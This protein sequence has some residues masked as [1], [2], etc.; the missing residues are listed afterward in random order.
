MIPI[1]ITFSWWNDQQIIHLNRI[2][3]HVPWPTPPS[4]RARGFLLAVVAPPVLPPALLLPPLQGLG[5]A[6]EEPVQLE[7][8][9]VCQVKPGKEAVEEWDLIEKIGKLDENDINLP[10]MIYIYIHIIIIFIWLCGWWSHILMDSNWWVNF[11]II[12]CKNKK[13]VYCTLKSKLKPPARSRLPVIAKTKSRA[14]GSTERIKDHGC[15]DFSETSQLPNHDMSEPPR[16][17]ASSVVHFLCT[18]PESYLVVH[19]T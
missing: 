3:P 5:A 7:E 10:N 8:G 14:G 13:Y 15:S 19:P 18:F 11:G 17:Q 16:L 12:T 9:D 1:N 4:G 6:R 2:F